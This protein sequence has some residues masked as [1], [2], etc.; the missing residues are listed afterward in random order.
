MTISHTIHL[1]SHAIERY[2]DRVRPGLSFEA[3]ELELARVAASGEITTHAPAWHL[4]TCAQEAP[5][6]LVIADV[7]LPL[8][9]HHSEIDVLVATTCLAQGCLSADA[10]RYRNARKRPR[11]GRRK[12]AL[13]A[14]A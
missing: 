10:R 4:R 12:T 5:Y 8:R 1:T 7:L 11:A 9:P 2:R 6:Y 13:P 3:A 14:L